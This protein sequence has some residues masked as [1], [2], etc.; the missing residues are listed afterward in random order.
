MNN[1][2]EE[3]LLILADS[4]IRELS[5]KEYNMQQINSIKHKYPELRQKSKAP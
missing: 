2:Q 5:V 4:E 1:K 3:P